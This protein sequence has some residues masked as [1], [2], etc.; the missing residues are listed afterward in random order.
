MIPLKVAI[1]IDTMVKHGREGVL[2]D[3]DDGKTREQVTLRDKHFD[4]NWKP[5][6]QLLADRR[7]ARDATRKAMLDHPA[8]LETQGGANAP[9]D[10]KRPAPAT[11]PREDGRAPHGRWP[12]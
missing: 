6:G 2:Y 5:L 10:A 11:L 9:A 3:S 8:R 12:L 7:D 1:A 4:P